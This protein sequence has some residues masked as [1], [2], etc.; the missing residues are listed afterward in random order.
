[1]A[2]ILEDAYSMVSHPRDSTH[3]HAPHPPVVT[4][5]L[6][7]VLLA[8]SSSSHSARFSGQV[9][10]RSADAQTCPGHPR[11]CE[12]ACLFGVFRLIFRL[13]LSL[14]LPPPHPTPP[15]FFF[16]GEFV[17]LVVEHVCYETPPVI[18]RVSRVLFLMSTG[19]VSWAAGRRCLGELLCLHDA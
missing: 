15:H 16:F 6:W 10:T 14:A 11:E 8:L 7:H 17:F 19:L 18:G 13:Q 4:P 2:R 5:S 3:E 12:T 9:R 1:M